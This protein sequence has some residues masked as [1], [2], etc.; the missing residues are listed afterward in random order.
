MSDLVEQLLNKRQQAIELAD[1]FWRLGEEYA[2]IAISLDSG[3]P[4][5][6]IV[7]YNT[8]KTQELRL[9]LLKYSQIKTELENLMQ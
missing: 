2:A 6:Y 5:Q 3:T 4:N 8:Q 1:E 7:T 9:L